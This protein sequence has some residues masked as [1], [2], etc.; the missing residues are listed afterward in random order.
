LDNFI[1]NGVKGVVYTIYIYYRFL[2]FK[3]TP[4]GRGNKVSNSVAGFHPLPKG[5][6]SK[7]VFFL[8]SVWRLRQTVFFLE[9]KYAISSIEDYL[10]LLIPKISKYFTSRNSKIL[11]KISRLAK[12]QNK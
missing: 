1:S 3:L 6:K 8:I 7:V 4:I 5:L 9:L 10:S 11:K 12:L 2:L